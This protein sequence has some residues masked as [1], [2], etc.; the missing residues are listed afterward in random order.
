MLASRF[1]LA[2]RAVTSAPTRVQYRHYAE[3][4]PATQAAKVKFS[5]ATPSEVFYSNTL[6]DTVI[7]PGSEGVFEVSPNLAP[8]I[9]QLNAGVVTVNTGAESKKF[10]ISG[11]FAFVHED[12][13]CSCN[14]VEC[15]DV[16]NLDPDLAKQALA[17]AQSRLAAASTDVE[18][19][20]AQIQVETATELVNAAV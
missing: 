19:A 13:T 2:R 5:L 17:R 8:I 15:V 11:G 6:V 3:A 1:F 20:V 9:T 7:L 14:P 10:F 16:E 18:K 4:V 12:S